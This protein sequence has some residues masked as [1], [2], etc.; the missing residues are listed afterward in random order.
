MVESFQVQLQV[1]VGGLHPEQLC[2]QECRACGLLAKS[3][4]DLPEK[5]E[6]K[7]NKLLTLFCLYV[8]I[9][10]ELNTFG[11]TFLK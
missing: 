4:R 10:F 9:Q 1:A 3:M 2:T 7:L 6:V 5:L 11:I 8:F